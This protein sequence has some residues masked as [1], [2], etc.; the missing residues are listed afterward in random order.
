MSVLIFT[1][2][3][4]GRRRARRLGLVIVERR[5]CRRLDVVENTSARLAMEQLLAVR[6]AHLL[7]YMRPDL[8]AAE[9]ALLITHFGKSDPAVLLRDAFVVVKQIFWNF[10]CNALTIGLDRFQIFVSR[11]LLRVDCRTL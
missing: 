2:G 5:H 8:H 9:R 4:S 1:G 11:R 3:R 10:R 6:I 7:K